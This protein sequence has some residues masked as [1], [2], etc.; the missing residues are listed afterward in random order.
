MDTS[1]YRKENIVSS[2]INLIHKNGVQALNI[3]DIAKSM[4][5]SVGTIFNYFAKKEDILMAVLDQYS[6]YDYDLFYSALQK[7][8]A[9]LAILFYFD[10]FATYYENYPEMTSIILASDVL[11]DVP[12]MKEKLNLI[13]KTRFENVQVL[14]EAAQS[15]GVIRKTLPAETLTDIFTS[16]FRG[17]CIRWRIQNYDFSLHLKTME[18]ITI[19]LDTF[20]PSNP[21]QNN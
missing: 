12:N 19:L 15:T 8:D 6:L 21:D 2:T 3:R 7:P 11:R 10:I 18:A 5:I 17:I 13:Y 16:T 14:I 4:G 20:S 1:L 9:K